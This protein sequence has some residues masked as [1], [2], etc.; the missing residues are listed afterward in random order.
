MEVSNLLNPPLETIPSKIHVPRDTRLEI[1]SLIH[2]TP[3]IE[4]SSSISRKH[5]RSPSSESTSINR[6]AAEQQISLLPSFNDDSEASD[7]LIS[8]DEDDTDSVAT[9][10]TDDEF[11][12]SS[13]GN[14]VSRSAAWTRKQNEKYKQDKNYNASSRKLRARMRKFVTKVKRLDPHAEVVDSKHIRHSKCGKIGTQDAPFKLSNFQKHI[15]S[16]CNGRA[17]SAG[18]GSHS[19]M[20]WFSK[21]GMSQLSSALESRIRAC[22][23]LSEADHPGIGILLDRTGALG[24]G[25]PSVTVLA[26]RLYGRSYKNLPL[27]KKQKVKL[28]QRREWQWEHHHNDGRV[29]STLCAQTLEA[30]DIDGPCFSCFSL[31]QLKGFR[32]A[33]SVPKPKIVNYKYLNKEYR[34]INL[35]TFLA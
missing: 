33:I 11:Y 19:L 34:N 14:G 8:D 13:K 18:A 24:G 27:R 1:S 25:A 9:V 6:A 35:G 22:P 26:K 3:W 31:L 30:S 28:L 5:S 29:Y 17:E 23:G 10:N 16:H 7:F 12:A 2:G 15:K 4:N 32:V 21:P 20:R